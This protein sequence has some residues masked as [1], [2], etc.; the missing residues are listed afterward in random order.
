VLETGP[1]TKDDLNRIQPAK[2]YPSLVKAGEAYAV[3]IPKPSEKLLGRSAPTVA[4]RCVGG[5]S[6]VNCMVQVMLHQSPKLTRCSSYGLL[7]YFR[8]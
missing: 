4:G 2:Y 7:S 5:G 1:H 3:H 8:F 6:A